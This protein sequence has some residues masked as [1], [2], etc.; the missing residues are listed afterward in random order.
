MLQS[1]TA[2]LA[3]LAQNQATGE[4]TWASWP[5]NRYAYEGGFWFSVARFVF[6]ALLLGAIALILRLLFGPKGPL[7]EKGFETIGE[8]K[9]REKR[10]REAEEA[11]KAEAEAARQGESDDPQQQS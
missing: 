7:R 9:A 6:V 4:T 2:L 5:F 10:E 1:L 3:A 8:A 11:A